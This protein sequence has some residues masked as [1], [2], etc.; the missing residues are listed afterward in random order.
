MFSFAIVDTKK[1]EI[2]IARDHFGI[3][4]LLY[5]VG[6]TY[7]MFG[8]EIQ[9]FTKHPQ[10]QKIIDVNAIYHYFQFGYIPAP[11]SIYKNL[12][13][14]EPGNY[15]R[16]SFDGK[17]IEQKEYYDIDFK[18][19]N[20]ISYQEWV[21]KVE[22]AIDTSVAY[23]KIADVPY[24]AFLSGGIDSSLISSSLAKHGKNVDVFTMGFHNH[25]FNEVPYAKEVAKK[26][27]LN[28]MENHFLIVQ[29]FQHTIL[30]K[31]LESI[32]LWFYLVMEVMKHLEATI[33]IRII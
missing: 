20:S 27:D 18:A 22:S 6:E 23:H 31:K 7:F 11:I 29:L 1:N 30:Q 24:G 8:S 4:P 9:Q 26:F 12:Y 15:L 13:K 2:F 3:K 16:V 33:V 10:F 17:I 5:Y 32:Y 21:S 25:K 19:D 14:L 28:I